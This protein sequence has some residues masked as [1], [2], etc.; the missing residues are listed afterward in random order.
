MKKN[1]FWV[2]S[3]HFSVAKCWGL[4]RRFRLQYSLEKFPFFNWVI[5]RFQLLPAVEFSRI[6]PTF[7]E[8]FDTLTHLRMPV[9]S[10][11]VTLAVVM[12][13]FLPWR[14]CDI[15]SLKS[16]SYIATQWLR[17]AQPKS[18]CRCCFLHGRDGALKFY[19]WMVSKV[20]VLL[21]PATAKNVCT[22][23]L[24]LGVKKIQTF[25]QHISLSISKVRTFGPRSSLAWHGS[26]DG[27]RFWSF[28]K[29][30][31][32]G[33]SHPRWSAPWSFERIWWGK[34]WRI[35]CLLRKCLSEK[36]H[37]QNR[38][39]ELWWKMGRWEDGKIE[40]CKRCLSIKHGQ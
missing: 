31:K 3:L 2:S 19:D 36:I 34:I 22:C 10:R 1:C 35:F 20:S 9:V 29:R 25:K 8:R 18:E 33:A 23:D 4:P 37:G 11:P 13:M 15:R 39:L 12:R 27:W 5:F 6:F 21:N 30:R 14:V 28:S 26:V 32:V 17:L 24:Y 38:F 40:R 16:T 7:S